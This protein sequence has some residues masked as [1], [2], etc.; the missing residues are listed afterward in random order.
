M[1]KVFTADNIAGLEEKDQ[2]L[3]AITMEA[4]QAE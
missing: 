1:A 2:L 4:G 3:P